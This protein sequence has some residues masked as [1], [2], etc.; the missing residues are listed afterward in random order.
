MVQKP[1]TSHVL[2]SVMIISVIIF[3]SAGAILLYKPIQGPN[4]FATN[5]FK[6]PKNSFQDPFQ[7]EEVRNPRTTASWGPW[8]SWSQC[9]YECLPGESQARTRTCSDQRLG[10]QVDLKLCLAHGSANSELRLC[11]CSTFERRTTTEREEN[12]EDQTTGKY[13]F[14]Y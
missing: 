11:E 1:K 5:L 7:T 9:S 12:K 4:T 6:R 13:Y 3:L 8:S 14:K 2:L 10:T